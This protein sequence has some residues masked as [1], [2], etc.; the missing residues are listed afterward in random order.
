M[1]PKIKDR[2]LFDVCVFDYLSLEEESNAKKSKD[3]TEQLKKLG[4]YLST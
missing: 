1:T 4:N 3:R 2:V